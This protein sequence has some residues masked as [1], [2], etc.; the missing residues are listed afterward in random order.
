MVSALAPNAFGVKDDV[1]FFG[2]LICRRDSLVWGKAYCNGLLDIEGKP[3]DAI[4]QAK[5]WRNQIN[6]QH[7]QYDSIARSYG[8]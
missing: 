7:E 3:A 4:A 8:D 1:L 5:W 2:D 6:E